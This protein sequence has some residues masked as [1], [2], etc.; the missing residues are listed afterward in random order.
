MWHPGLKEMMYLNATRRY[1][2]RSPARGQCSPGT[3]YRFLEMLTNNLAVVFIEKCPGTSVRSSIPIQNQSNYLCVGLS[4]IVTGVDE[5]AV[6]KCHRGSPTK[7]EEQHKQQGQP[8]G[9]IILK[10]QSVS[11]GT[12]ILEKEVNKCHMMLAH[13]RRS[14][15]N[16]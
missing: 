11:A 7:P 2:M 8:R 10:F 5:S 12:S 16:N 1:E 9:Y 14:I 6:R 13:N 15:H 3:Y 4:T